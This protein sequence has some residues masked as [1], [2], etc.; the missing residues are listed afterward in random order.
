MPFVD[1]KS[2]KAIDHATR[3][4][5][6]EEIVKIMPLIPGKDATNT[7]FAISDNYSM[8]K[9]HQPVDAV[10]VEVR[11]YKQSPHDA[12]KSFVSAI[13]PI[14]EKVLGVQPKYVNLNFTEMDTWAV[15]GDYF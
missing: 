1:I 3:N 4:V 7:L 15:G 13:T 12:K 8:F 2:S 6:Q 9:E 5:L 10:F 11:M 14:F